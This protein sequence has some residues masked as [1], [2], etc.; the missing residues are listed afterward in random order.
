MSTRVPAAAPL[1]VCIGEVLWDLL[2][3]G[4]VLGGAP[5]NV[6]AHAVQ[7][8]I[9]G[10]AISAVGEDTDGLEILNRLREMNVLVEGM[11][12]VTGLPTGVVDVMLDGAGV[13][14]FS[15]RKPAAWD[16]IL[17]DDCIEKLVQN[18]DSVVFGSL[19]QRDPRS[20]Q[21]I[22]QLLQECR[23]ECLRVFD[24]NLRHPFYNGE[25]VR[26]SLALANV[27]KLSDEELPIISDMLGLSGEEDDRL[28]VLRRRYDLDLLIYTKGAKGSR[29]MAAG[30]DESHP[31]YPV[32]V[33]DTVGAGDAFTAAVIVGRL[34]GIE[35]VC[36]QD[37][38]NRVAAYVCTQTG[39]APRLPVDI[40]SQFV[41][42]GG[43]E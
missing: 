17:V 41:C 11:R 18:A 27:L 25:I 1:C 31:G 13:P 5:I 36:L 15:I 34:L 28:G 37:L 20:R 23:P 33:V 35:L 2:P 30:Q 32:F 24:V 14:S 16:A 39:A 22:R 9:R 26:S 3:G 21:A 40:V 4:K 38:A 7:L 6:A 19:A 12:V 29:I 10:A 42:Y 8:G 43:D